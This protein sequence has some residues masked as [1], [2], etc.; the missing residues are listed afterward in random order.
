MITLSARKGTPLESGKSIDETMAS[1]EDMSTKDDLQILVARNED[2]VILGWIYYFVGIPPMAFIDGFLPIVDPTRS[3]EA[4]AMALIEA[5]KRNIVARAYTRLEIELKLQ[6]DAHRTLSK[7]FIDWYEKCDFRF[8]AEEVHMISD[9][10]SYRLSKRSS[11]KDCALRMFSD[12]SYDKLED[13]GFRAFGNSNDD[14]F[15]SMRRAEQ[16]VE[17][18]HFFNA[19]KPFIENASF[20]LEREGKIA[21]FVI[22]RMRNE[23]AEIGPI[24][25]IP[26][27]RGQGLGGYLLACALKSLKKSGMTT[28]SLDM[29]IANH[30][31]KKLYRQYGFK[32]VYYKQFYYWSP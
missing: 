28:V 31:A 2:G 17:L 21:G 22:T 18:E 20:V 19:S 15:L 11:P 14:L 10:K 7:G 3:S 4:I 13:A 12:V 6:N 24:G 9:L 5:S 23:E 8:A 1:I 29:S 25:L 30:P 27:A 26:E 16:K 32:D